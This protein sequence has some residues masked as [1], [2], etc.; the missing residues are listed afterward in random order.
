[1]APKPPK[2]TPTIFA[3]YWIFMTHF[4]PNFEEI[5][6]PNNP[7]HQISLYLTIHQIAENTSDRAVRVEIQRIANK[8]IAD[9]AQKNSK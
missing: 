6:D 4:I 8:A 2:L 5:I 3:S 1:M 9:I 7:H